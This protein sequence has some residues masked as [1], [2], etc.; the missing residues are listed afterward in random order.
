MSAQLVYIVSLPPTY[1]AGFVCLQRA[2]LFGIVSS[3]SCIS[4]I[5]QRFFFF[6]VLLFFFLFSCSLA[7]YKKHKEECTNKRKSPSDSSHDSSSSSSSSSSVS[8]SSLSSNVN[9]KVHQGNECGLIKTPKTT[10]NDGDKDNNYDGSDG[11]GPDSENPYQGVLSEG[12]MNALVHSERI[13][14]ALRHKELREI[15]EVIM[16]EGPQYRYQRNNGYG[17]NKR[18]RYNQ[19]HRPEYRLQQ[20]IVNNQDFGVFIND[21]LEVIGNGNEVDSTEAVGV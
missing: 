11:N 12:E 19:R 7:C 1:R 15:I 13:V 2:I 14:R 17:S 8:T 18:Q 5:T 4:H 10:G 3:S 9:N 21:V 16:G 20:F 6:L